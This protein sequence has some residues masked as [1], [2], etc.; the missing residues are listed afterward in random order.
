[1]QLAW[2]I[3]RA[4]LLPIRLRDLHRS[5]AVYVATVARCNGRRRGVRQRE[6]LGIVPHAIPP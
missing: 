4:A 2:A 1:M 6:A 5:L 3:L